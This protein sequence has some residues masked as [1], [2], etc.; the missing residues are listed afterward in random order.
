MKTLVRIF[1]ACLGIALLAFSTFA[2]AENW[3]SRPIRVIVPFA[4]GGGTDI[5]A[6][7]MAPKL[8]ALLGQSIVVDDKP[9]ASSIIGS[10]LVA[11]AAPDG[12]TILM[13]D[14]TF[15][16]NP[17][18][19]PN[20]P[21]DSV[22]D[23]EPVIHLATGPVILVANPS[24]AAKN[25]RELIAEAKTHPGKLFYGSGGIG[26]STHLAGE[27]FNLAAGVKITH[28]IYLIIDK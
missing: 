20:L 8:S 27:L 12:Y 25:V 21:Y 6:R 3:P 10:Q 18:L 11:R 17:G 22:K 2:L 5:L 7:L 14:S 1:S 28:E 23:F 9:G 26:A 4:A 24:L 19:R 13:V 16:I 15:L